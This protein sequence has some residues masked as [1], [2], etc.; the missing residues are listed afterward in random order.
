[1]TSHDDDFRRIAILKRPLNF[2]FLAFCGIIY[3]I[4]YT[5]RFILQ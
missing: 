5:D 2:Y 4:C 3:Q 1:M